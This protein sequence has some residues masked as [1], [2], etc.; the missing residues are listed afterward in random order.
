[1]SVGEAAHIRGAKP[2]SARYVESMTPEERS[3]ITNGIWLCN[4]CAKLIDDDESFF[5]VDVLYEWKRQHEERISEQLGAPAGE[6]E[7]RRILARAF[8]SDGPAAIQI[9]LDRPDNWAALLAIELL[10]EMIGP[11]R[12][13]L[14]DLKRGVAP[15]L[16]RTIEL[17]DIP[18]WVRERMNDL[19][20]C[21][22]AIVKLV[23]EDLQEALARSPHSGPLDIRRVCERIRRVCHSLLEWEREVDRRLLP[24][25]LDSLRLKMQGWTDNMFTQLEHLPEE[26]SKPFREQVAP[27]GAATVR[28]VFAVPVDMDWVCTELLARV[29]ALVD[30]G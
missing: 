8:E 18:A 23:C 3:S 6:S 24:Y 25:E 16:S 4:I 20:R 17:K 14:L 22:T 27:T 21:V 28:I 11:I 13:D 10:R 15:F 12:Q 30:A 29:D 2:D 26:M 5:S 9:V 7:R 1:M 19:K